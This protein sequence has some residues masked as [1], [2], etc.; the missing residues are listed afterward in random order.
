MAERLNPTNPQLALL[1]EFV[2]WA[3]EACSRRK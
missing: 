3:D 2:R 1:R